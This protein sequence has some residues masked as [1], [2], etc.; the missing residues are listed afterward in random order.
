MGTG[1]SRQKDRCQIRTSTIDNIE[2]VNHEEAMQQMTVQY[3]RPRVISL[4]QYRVQL[5]IETYIITLRSNNIENIVNTNELIERLTTFTYMVNELDNTSTSSNP[6]D[7][8]Q[9]KTYIL[10]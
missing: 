5:P 1:I 9:Y 2:P 3:Y 10:N 8:D 4:N 6:T 7:V